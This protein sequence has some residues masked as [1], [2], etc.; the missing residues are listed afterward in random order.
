MGGLASA[1]PVQAIL[2]HE[3]VVYATAGLLGFMDGSVMSAV[4][5]KTGVERWTKVYRDTEFTPDDSRAARPS[6]IPPPGHCIKP[7]MNPAWRCPIR[8]FT[9]Y[10]EDT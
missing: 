3:G 6:S 2:A 1:W 10:G 8:A 7:S 9:G 5:A 4:D